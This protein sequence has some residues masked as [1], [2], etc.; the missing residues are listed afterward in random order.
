VGENI[1]TIK[2]NTVALLVAIME[3]GPE[4]SAVKDKQRKKQNTGRC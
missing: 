2:K 4:V 1:N 3:F